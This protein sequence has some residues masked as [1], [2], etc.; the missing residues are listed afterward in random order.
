MNERLFCFGL[1]FSAG[2]LA[3]RCLAKGWQVAG[4]ARE[5][6]RV[7]AL[8]D[9]DVQA[10]RFDRNHD[11]PFEALDGATHLLISVPPDEDGD[12]VLDRVADRIKAA[13]PQ[14]IGYLS[15]TG[16]YGDHQGGWVDEQTPVS[17]ASLRSRRRAEAESRW[18]ALG[19]QV[20][21]LA[22]IYGPGRSVLD[23]VR[24][25]TAQCIVKPG[26]VFSRIHVEDI[27]T[28][29]EAS[30]GRPRPGAIYNVCDDEAAPPQD[31]VA[32]ACRLL[33]VDPPPEVPFE[34]A[35]LSPMAQSFWADNKRVGNRLLH[36]ELGVEL[37]YPSYREG[38][39]SLL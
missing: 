12:P 8:R 26:Q 16:V 13:A 2:I 15:T 35:A 9:A 36:E 10:Y 24:R 3:R 37:T 34:Q 29:L 31:V 39:E 32:Y 27:A 5:P 20:F 7:K 18:L 38:L 11:L 17:P 21:R 28:V 23:D 6:A 33:G 30:M 25:G 19:A 4:T 22:G 14:W 1:G